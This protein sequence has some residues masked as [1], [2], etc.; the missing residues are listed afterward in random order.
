M[1]MPRE[2]SSKKFPVVAFMAKARVYHLI[3]E[4]DN[5]CRR[6]RGAVPGR[7]GSAL[8]RARDAVSRRRAREVAGRARLRHRAARI[9]R[10]LHLHGA[11]DVVLVV[12]GLRVAVDPV[13]A[14]ADLLRGELGLRRLLLRRSVAAAEDVADAEL[15]LVALADDGAVEL[16]RRVRLL[17]GVVGLRAAAR[18]LVGLLL[19]ALVVALVVAVRL[20]RARLLRIVVVRR[21]AGRA[22]GDRG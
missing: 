16:G 17:R 2:K 1:R 6:L 7:E 9:D 19:R 10:Q 11:R 12:A 5:E 20:L 13:E 3:R 22:R 15:V 21:V 14:G 18:L 8:H 4:Q